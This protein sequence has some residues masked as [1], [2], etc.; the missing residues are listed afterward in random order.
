MVLASKIHC[1]GNIVGISCGNGINAG[2]G[3]PGIRPTQGLGQARLI[4]DVVRVVKVFDDI[5]TRGARM[6]LGTQL[7][8]TAL[9]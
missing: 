7:A 5:L 3:T 9:R 6:R 1:C 2:L 8:E 4:A